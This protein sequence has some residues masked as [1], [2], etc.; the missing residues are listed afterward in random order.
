MKPN[1][2][3]IE[4]AFELAATGRFASATEIKLKLAREGYRH[5]QVE[6][7]ALAKQIRAIIEKARRRP[8]AVKSDA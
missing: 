5:E 8:G 6:G 2:S 3:A 1:V 4:R 7:R